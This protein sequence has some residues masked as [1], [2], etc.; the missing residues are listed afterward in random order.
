[1]EEKKMNELLA[2]VMNGLTAEQKEKAAACKDNQELI[3]LLGDMGV[4]LPD[5]LLDDAAGGF[6]VRTAKM[7]QASKGFS[8]AKSTGVLRSTDSSNPFSAT[9]DTTATRDAST[10]DI[11]KFN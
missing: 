5:E 3:A 11:D 8:V 4:A 1:M 6:V 2:G 9:R 7:N 10:R